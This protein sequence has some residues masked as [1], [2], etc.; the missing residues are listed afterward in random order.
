M[1]DDMKLTAKVAVEVMDDVLQNFEE[2]LSDVLKK[3]KAV[4][5]TAKEF[6]NEIPQAN[7]V[8]KILKKTVKEL[9]RE[10]EALRD[11]TKEQ[12]RNT[13]EKEKNTKQSKHQYNAAGKTA[14]AFGGLTAKMA[15]FRV[16]LGL[17]S[18]AAG[19]LTSALAVP[20]GVIAGWTFFLKQISDTERRLQAAAQAVGV[21]SNFLAGLTVVAEDAGL[22]MENASDNLEELVNR[23]GDAIEDPGGKSGTMFSRIG[24]DAVQLR[25]DLQALGRE[26]TY[27]KVID[28]ILSSDLTDALKIRAGDELFGGEGNRILATFVRLQKETG[29]TGSALIDMYSNAVGKSKEATQAANSFSRSMELSGK[30]IQSIFI[31]SLRD[32]F[33]TTEELFNSLNSYVTENKKSIIQIGRDISATLTDL[34]FYVSNL[35]L[36][37]ILIIVKN[38]DIL[39]DIGKVL[40]FIF[41]VGTKA[42]LGFLKVFS[43]LPTEMRYFLATL[44]PLKIA[45]SGVVASFIAMNAPVLGIIA[46]ITLVGYALNQVVDNWDGI[47]DG[48]DVVWEYWKEVFSDMYDSVALFISNVWD[49]IKGFATSIKEAF[50]SIGDA[51][52]D[53]WSGMMEKFERFSKVFTDGWKTLKS[54]AGFDDEDKPSPEYKSKMDS[55]RD[56]LNNASMLRFQAVSGVEKS[57][58]TN[59]SSTITNN[60]SGDTNVTINAGS[61]DA[62]EI[63]EMLIESKGNH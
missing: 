42:V 63:H 21:S 31:E 7:K 54:L 46:L 13:K 62:A 60:T 11:N 9:H 20:A 45:M 53:L 29:K 32:A 55:W 56:Q 23:V 3:M 43:A 16:V 28:S 61:A 2:L 34:F 25:D 39:M 5:K 44:G 41:D 48:L 52:N 27:K 14:A 8:E 18:F 38:K 57:S 24:L 26:T 49:K 30:I 1:A 40:F 36:D 10:E 51:W 58:T 19:L 37:M 33:R 50:S 4:D 47:V 12:K 17:A 6:L 22:S 35:F 59:T 15:Q